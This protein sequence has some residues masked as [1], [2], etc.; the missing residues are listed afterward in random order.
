MEL[1]PILHQT[2]GSHTDHLLFEDCSNV[3]RLMPEQLMPRR[4]IQ[5]MNLT[6]GIRHCLYRRSSIL[7]KLPQAKLGF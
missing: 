6:L 1:R 7:Q 3:Q 2:E 5:E 4:H